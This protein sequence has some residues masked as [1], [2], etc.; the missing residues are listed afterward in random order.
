MKPGAIIS[1]TELNTTDLKLK[2][3]KVYEVENPQRTAHVYSRRDYYKVSLVVSQCLIHYASKSLVLDG[4]YLFFSNPHIPYSVEL[5]TEQ[6]RGY[7]CLFTEE[8]VKASDRSESLQQSP[9][10][11]LSGAPLFKLTDEQA[12]YA[13]SIFQKMLA[14]QETA[15]PFKGD[16][17]R[18]YI[19]LL[20]HE[21]LH[22]QP[23]ETFF[24]HKNAASRITAL[25]LE[26][27]ERLF[28]IENPHLK[29]PLKTAQE[30]ANRLA[31]HVNHLNRAV[32]EVTGKST[33]A[34][35][36][37]R[38]VDEATALLQYTDWSVADIAYSLGFEYPIY[39]NN[40]FKKHTGRTPLALRRPA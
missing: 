26:L 8:F 29:L 24:Q 19:Q 36:A 2:G 31:I 5:L 40:F 25:F 10:F 4:T 33:S 20:I 18:T 27:L 9:L 32:K 35:I 17:I 23:T 38:I 15:Y 13:T 3:F 22:M 1:P 16:L 30:F 6:H 14:E 39:F 34:H 12:A 37:G 7:A 28:P 21:A 11:Q